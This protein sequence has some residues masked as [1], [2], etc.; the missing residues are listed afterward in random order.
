MGLKDWLLKRWGVRTVEFQCQCGRTN[1]VLVTPS[2]LRPH[3]A[4]S[5]ELRAWK[6]IQWA[7]VKKAEDWY[8]R[9]KTDKRT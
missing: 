9:K 5:P 2:L 4:D 3:P 6:M 1:Q 7:R 8:A